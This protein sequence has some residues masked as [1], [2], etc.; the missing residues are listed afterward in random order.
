MNCAIY[1]LSFLGLLF[2]AVLVVDVGVCISIRLPWFLARKFPWTDVDRWEQAVCRRGCRMARAMK[3]VPSC[4]LGRYVIWEMV[5]G[6]YSHD[7]LQGW[8][9]GPLVYALCSL[10]QRKEGNFRVHLRDPQ[11]LDDGFLMFY[12]NLAGC[13]EDSDLRCLG[14]KYFS[15]VQSRLTE[16][17]AVVYRNGGRIAFVDAVAFTC[18][19]LMRLS[20]VTNDKR[21][22]SVAMGIMR[23]FRAH[24]VDA[25]SH[26]VFHGYDT[27][28]LLPCDSLGW[29]RG[30]AWYLLGLMYSYSECMDMVDREW[31]SSAM[32]EGADV[33]LECQQK[34][35][36]WGTR[37][38]R[39]SGFD[40][41]ATAMFAYYLA[42]LANWDMDENG[43]FLA[44]CSLA[45]KK[46][47]QSTDPWGAVTHAEGDCHDIGTYSNRYDISPL[48][49]GMTI[50]A[51]EELKIARK[52]EQSL[53]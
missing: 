29:G 52:R 41:S 36:G 35:G 7:C 23:D 38:V 24:G 1:V 28:S 15:L 42:R 31:L 39:G 25:K 11:E 17:G 3:R 34:D 44:A 6:R 4:D 49:Q 40:S 19:V 26:L 14:E 53:G 20:S 8:Q 21:Y 30:T 12:M 47:R 9:Y 51:I 43:A 2:I 45:I 16:R 22:A 32:K 5:C 10:G 37:L 13:L 18:P 50:L 27:V 48:A 33:L 46:L